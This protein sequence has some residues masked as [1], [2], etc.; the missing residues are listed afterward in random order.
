MPNGQIAGVM[1][2]FGPG[3]APNQDG[4]S[5]KPPSARHGT[6]R[7][8]P[9]RHRT[10]TQRSVR[11]GY[12]QVGGMHNSCRKAQVPIGSRGNTGLEFAERPNCRS[13]AH[14]HTRRPRIVP[15]PAPAVAVAVAVAVAA[16]IPSTGHGTQTSGKAAAHVCTSRS[17][18]RLTGPRRHG[19]T[20]RASPS[21]WLGPPDRKSVV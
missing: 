5:R 17:D 18:S 9:A 12:A 15:T 13:Y 16:V 11:H 4:R 2:A 21:A 7:H 20:S 8:G 3:T 1:H 14:P 10:A 19:R 6:A